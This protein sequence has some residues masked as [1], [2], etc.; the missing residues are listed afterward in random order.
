MLDLGCGTGYGCEMLSWIARRVR[1][2]D[3]WQPEAAERP[4]WPGGAEFNYGHDLCV[5][6]LPRADAATMFEVVEHLPDAPAMLRLAFDAVDTDRPLVPEPGPPRVAH[7]PA[8]RQRLDAGRVRG[9]PAR[10]RAVRPRARAAPPVAGLRREPRA[11][12]RSEASY[13]I[14]VAAALAPDAWQPCATNAG[15]SGQY[16]ASTRNVAEPRVERLGPEVRAV[17]GDDEVRRVDLEAVV[18]RR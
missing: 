17:L 6:A 13:W 16:R 12:P 5:D 14:V 1:G 8:P 11:G 18:A 10:R 3:L 9:P 4:A 7:Q 15:A 2:F